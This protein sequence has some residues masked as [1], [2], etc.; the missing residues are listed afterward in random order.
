MELVV[1]A[2]A[3]AAY[4][5]TVSRRSMAVPALSMAVPVQSTGISTVN[6]NMWIYTDRV[7]S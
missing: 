4:D 7:S 6:K 5:C 3:Q 1:T 2:A